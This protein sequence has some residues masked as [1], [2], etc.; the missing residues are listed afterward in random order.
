MTTE[1]ENLLVP[2]RVAHA[3]WKEHAFRGH[4]VFADLLGHTS[5]SGM[6]VLA[7]GERLPTEDDC[8]FLDELAV[9]STFADPR[10]WPLK[11]ARLVGSYGRFAPGL[12]AGYLAV[13]DADVGPAVC[14]PIARA[15]RQIHE[16][17]GRDAAD[18]MPA[19]EAW[20]HETL[21]S[22]QRILGFG[23]PF[24]TPDE[25][26]VALE[27][28]LVAR[29][30]AGRP[31]W[32]L[33]QRVATVVRRER[34]IEP[35]IASGLAAALLDMGFGPDVIGPLAMLLFEITFVA[36]AMEAAVEP[37]PVMRELPID[38]IEYVGRPARESLRAKAATPS[39]AR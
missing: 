5:L 39:G 11:A 22:S 6:L 27:E 28:R 24:R 8:A 19:I 13:D 17:A 15:L 3:Y 26:M 25:R 31:H 29:G 16:K 4:R 7:L 21:A 32:V 35:N 10:I 18:A 33:L 2:T 9:I 1:P 34:G 20:V 12:V 14:A 23:V 37:A 30:R 38:R 36:N